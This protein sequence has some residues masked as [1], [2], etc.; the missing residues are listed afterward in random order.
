M[1]RMEL[2]AVARTHRGLVRQRNEDA[3]CLWPEAEG[4]AAREALL[5]AVADGMGGH[6]GGDR[7]SASAVRSMAGQDWP[8]PID[9]RSWLSA[10]FRRAGERIA[11]E[12]R[13][14]PSLAGMGTTLVATLFLP[15]GVWAASVGDSRLYWI[16]G[17]WLT[18]VTRDH[19]MASDLVRRGLLDA[20]EADQHPSSH[21][22]T[23]CLGTCAD[24]TPDLP[25]RPLHP[26]PGDQFL[27]TSDGLGRAVDAGRVPSLMRGDSS[28]AAGALIDAALEGGAPDNVTVIVVRWLSEAPAARGGVN[29]EEASAWDR[30]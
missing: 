7:A 2:D 30:A 8:P 19:T 9:P 15:D 17:D 4:P 25:W 26:L 5:A 12:A 21:L 28:A 24:A 3:A 18:L 6:P 22:L 1:D 14:E 16:R 13:D 23:R 27:L 10:A 11:R 20:A 29:F